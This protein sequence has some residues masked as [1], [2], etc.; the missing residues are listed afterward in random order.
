M[1]LGYA[2]GKSGWRHW[3]DRAMRRE[4]IQPRASAAGCPVRAERAL[5]VVREPCG[6]A[7]DSACCRDRPATPAVKLLCAFLEDWRS[8]LRRAQ[9]AVGSCLVYLKSAGNQCSLVLSCSEFIYELLF[10]RI[11]AVTEVAQVQLCPV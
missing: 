2:T 7:E 1:F 3:R 11:C 4:Q 5:G 9:P 8:C 6:G 10:I